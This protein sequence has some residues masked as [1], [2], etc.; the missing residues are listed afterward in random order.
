MGLACHIVSVLTQR[1]M[2]NITAILSLGISGP[3]KTKVAASAQI[4]GN[5]ISDI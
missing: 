5:Y 4:T 1:T 3:N 2:H